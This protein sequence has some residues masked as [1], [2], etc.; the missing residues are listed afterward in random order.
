MPLA[1]KV[2]NLLIADFLTISPCGNEVYLSTKSGEVKKNFM[3]K[4]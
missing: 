1:C 2:Q 4:L 3:T